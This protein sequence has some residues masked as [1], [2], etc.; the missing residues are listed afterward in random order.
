MWSFEISKEIFTIWLYIVFL[1]FTLFAE[2]QGSICLVAHDSHFVSLSELCF[3]DQVMSHFCEFT[4]W[5]RLYCSRWLQQY[6]QSHMLFTTLPFSSKNGVYFPLLVLPALLKWSP[7]RVFLPGVIRANR[8]R[9]SSVQKQRKA[10][11]FG[12]RMET[13]EHMLSRTGRGWGCFIGSG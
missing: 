11:F 10:L 7:R 3:P 6:L 13:C 1:F 4:Q 8:T 12:Q 2:F 9:P 5:G